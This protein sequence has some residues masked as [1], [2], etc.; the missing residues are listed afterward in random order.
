MMMS[1]MAPHRI[2]LLLVS[3]ALIVAAC[4]ADDPPANADSVDE[5][6]FEDA[7][8]SADE[9]ELDPN[10]IPESEAA[11]LRASC[12]FGPGAMAA[13]TIGREYPIGDDIPI[14]HFIMVML[15]NR[16]FDHYFGTMGGVD[17]IPEDAGNPDSTGRIRRPFHEDDYCINDVSHSWNASHVQ[18]ND[19]AM[20]GFVTTNEPDGVRAMGYFDADDLPFYWDLYIT[21]A[22]SDRHFCSVLG[23]TWINRWYFFS[24][25]SVGMIRNQFSPPERL[26]DPYTVLQLLD[27][28]EVPWRI[29]FS[30]VPFVYGA[31]P[32]LTIGR[33]ADVVRNSQFFEDLEAGNLPPV[34][35]LDP[36]FRQ[37]VE[38]TDEHPPANPQFGQQ[39]I[40]ELVN[41]VFESPD[42]EST[43]LILTYDEHGG[44]WDHVAP[45]EACAPGDYPPDLQP[46]DWNADFD[47]LGFRVPLVVVSPFSRA[48]YVSHEVTDLASVLRLIEVRFGLPALTGRDANAWPMLDMFDFED[49]P[50]LE[51][52][53]LEAA[54]I[55]EAKNATCH[56][57]FGP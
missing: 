48:G 5:T 13:D 28:A 22:M 4:G 31:Y 30:D 29:Y 24:G 38:Q 32:E 49:P 50:F 45:P 9:P 39:F 19:G 6:T 41:A 11:E 26:E 7:G 14:E 54:V 8:D 40:E 17:G 21:F 52:P 47:R 43:A 27:T 51:P 12:A 1:A 56:R 25:T 55:D 10:R 16:S 23:P 20:D 3:A 15:E 18:F 57:R 44:F 46:G 36:S 37:G 53:V 33:G 35:Y 2:R 34:V 42:W